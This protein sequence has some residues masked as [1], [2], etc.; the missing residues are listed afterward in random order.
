MNRAQV[1]KRRDATLA[2]IGNAWQRPPVSALVHDLEW[3]AN[4]HRIDMRV[5]G[6]GPQ[7]HREVRRFLNGR[8][9][10][11]EPDVNRY[12]LTLFEDPKEI[13]RLVAEGEWSSSDTGHGVDSVKG[14]Q[15]K[16]R[17]GKA[18]G[19]C[20]SIAENGVKN[21]IILKPAWHPRSYFGLEEKKGV[22]AGNG[23]HRT[24]CAADLGVPF[25][26]VTWRT[27]TMGSQW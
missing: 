24:A 1:A 19:T 8:V 25:I 6:R 11:A 17:E 22:Q 18:N 21:P 27:S 5:K 9:P 4:N 15:R 10:T 16:L 2:S 3:L 20:A 26:P 23:H 13:L 7:R 12:Q 14:Y